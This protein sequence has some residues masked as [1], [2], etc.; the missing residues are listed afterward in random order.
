MQHKKWD[1]FKYTTLS[2]IVFLWLTGSFALAQETTTHLFIT[3][4]DAGSPPSIE[5]HVYGKDGRG[6]AVDLAEASFSVR[7]NDIP[8][9][10]V[11]QYGVYT[12]G[13]F[14]LFLIDIP[15]GVSDQLPAIQ[16]AIIQ[17]ASSP[18]MAEQVDFVAI[19][20]VGE[21][22]A[23][24]MLPPNAFYNGVR[25][26]FASQLAPESAATALVDSTMSLL[27][28]VESLKPNVDMYASLV[29][30]TDGTDVV[31]TQFEP[32]EVAERATELNIPIH[33]IWLQN[34]D[35]SPAS[36]E[37]GQDYLSD[38]AIDTGGLSVR[39]EDDSDL[40]MIWNRIARFRDQI[41]LRYTVSEISG[42]TFPV[43]LSL[44]ATPDALAETTVTIAANSPS[45]VINLP[46]ESRTLSL[47]SLEDPVELHFSTS[48]AWLDG[49]ERQLTAA[50]LIVNELSPLSIPLENIDDFDLEVNNLIFGNNAI[51]V[52]I[53]DEQGLRVTSPPMLL[54]ITEGDRS[55]P[56]ELRPSNRIG[57]LLGSIFVGLAVLAVLTGTGFL[58]WRKG[59]L[60]QAPSL[61]PR[62]RSARTR[63][64]LASPPA[65]SRSTN[66]AVIDGAEQPPSRAVAQLD[67]LE[68][69]SRVPT[70]IPLGRTHVRIGRSPSQSDISFENDITVSRIHATLML[71]GDH[72]R[73]FDERSTSGTWV[74]EQQVP[75]Y[76]IQLTDGDELHLGAV[77]L[78]YRQP[79]SP[80]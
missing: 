63:E 52:A 30:I 57:S 71:E 35:L 75:E 38:V 58:V 44:A 80:A 74:N 5:L 29:I 27:E 11:E 40:S 50:Q 68:S 43:R 59:W 28:R 26:L 13:T 39:L 45:V 60:S 14:T 25:N 46:L 24:E 3:G 9:G 78:R 55:I 48:V 54:T 70:K 17:F 41:R 6:D 33:T 53:L 7:H 67:V 15:T 56:A 36:R 69:V 19:Y 37:L 73:I 79:N 72:Y 66:A 22:N 49:V 4:T 51:R 42:G 1:W 21:T 18:T 23:L 34:S 12:A 16:D 47:P 76:G 32:D 65:V 20:Q 31:S 10:Q 62:G 2:L 61:I 8:A 77:H 64:K